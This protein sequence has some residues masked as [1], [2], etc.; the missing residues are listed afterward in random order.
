VVQADDGETCDDANDVSGC[1]PDQPQK[2]LD[3]CLNSCQ[4][5]MCDDPSKIKLNDEAVSG[6]KDLVQV[7]GRLITGTEVHFESEDFE[8]KISRRVC[9]HDPSLPCD[10]DQDCDALSSGSTCTPGGDASVVFAQALQAG[11]I[12]HP[13]PK[14]WNYK[15][16]QAKIDGGIYSLKIASKMT[17]PTC[18]G[19]SADGMSCALGD[20]C[21][22][23]DACV[24]YYKFTLKAY[25]DAERAV[26][27]MQTQILA[28]TRRWA[29]R[30]QWQQLSSGWKLNKQSTFLEPWPYEPAP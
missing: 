12:P 22:G 19:R 18:A 27:D 16:P 1:R 29:V 15:N 25:G 14:S 7:H 6:N 20:G 4:E 23:E 5:P 24:G 11:T 9:S 21:P 2:P 13:L 10:S 17:A 8:V 26:S 30:G 28:G 3:G